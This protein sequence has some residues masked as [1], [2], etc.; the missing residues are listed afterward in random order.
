MQ[1]FLEVIPSNLEGH[2]IL[3]S[4]YIDSA[5]LI[6]TFI[7]VIQKLPELVPAMLT[8]G[9]NPNAQIIIDES[10][11]IVRFDLTYEKVDRKKYMDTALMAAVSNPDVVKV[12]IE[13]GADVNAK[14]SEG[15]TALKRAKSK[16]YAES[17][18]LLT[19]AHG[20]KKR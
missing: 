14:T 4:Y 9:A 10:I 1:K 8:K 16:G 2:S 13:A 6:P 3:N 12:L 11:K 15:E 7:L 19:E 17:V 5:K 20:T 18:K